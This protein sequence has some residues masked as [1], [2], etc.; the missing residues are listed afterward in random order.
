VEELT[1]PPENL[2]ALLLGPVTSNPTVGDST[3]SQLV[4]L[5]TIL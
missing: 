2:Y 3:G 4:P 5:N 1:P